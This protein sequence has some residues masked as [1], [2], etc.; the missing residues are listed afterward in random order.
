MKWYLPKTSVKWDRVGTETGKNI[1]K[2]PPFWFSNEE[3]QEYEI[4]MKTT[5][6]TKKNISVAA[7]FNIASNFLTFYFSHLIGKKAGISIE[8]FLFHTLSYIQDNPA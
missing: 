4:Q 3:I 2:L 8:F 6:Q 7:K 1:S 5:M